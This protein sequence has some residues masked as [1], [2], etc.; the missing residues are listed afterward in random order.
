MTTENVRIVRLA[1]VVGTYI[2]V[3]VVGSAWLVASTPAAAGE[4][5]VAPPGGSAAGAAAQSAREVRQRAAVEGRRHGEPEFSSPNILIIEGVN[6]NNVWTGSSPAAGSGAAYNRLR[7]N[8]SR[9][10]DDNNSPAR[11]VVLVPVPDA[12]VHTTPEAQSAHSNRS[13]ANVYR[14]RD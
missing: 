1:A 13:R 9:T 14:Q 6:G 4:I 2:L 5:I 3:T 7:A 8:E 11:S 10:R 12:N